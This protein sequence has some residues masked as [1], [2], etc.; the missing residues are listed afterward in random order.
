MD[1]A[2][3]PIAMDGVGLNAAS[4]VYPVWKLPKATLDGKNCFAVE[5]IQVIAEEELADHFFAVG[6]VAEQF[7]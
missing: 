3:E 6:A 5:S 1:K 7:E 2:L 4:R